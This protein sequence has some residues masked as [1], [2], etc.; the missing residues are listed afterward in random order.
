MSHLF[1]RSA[2]KTK[3]YL[4]TVMTLWT[5]ISSTAW[6]RWGW[7]AICAK[8]TRRT[9]SSYILLSRLCAE[10]SSRA[11]QAVSQCRF[12]N[13]WHPCL[14]SLIPFLMRSSISIKWFVCLSV[15][16]PVRWLVTQWQTSRQGHQTDMSNSVKQVRNTGM[17]FDNLTIN[18]HTLVNYLWKANTVD[19][20]FSK[21][22]GTKAK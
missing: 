12:P 3:A 18:S 6:G 16:A 8:I 20:L 15:H 21:I 1:N 14:S 11:V 19:F 2:V 17:K 10:K 7:W 13:A 5:N 9:Y 22:Q 4:W